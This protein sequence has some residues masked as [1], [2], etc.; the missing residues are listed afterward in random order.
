[1]LNF[2]PLIKNASSAGQHKRKMECR[3]NE[4]KTKRRRDKWEQPQVRD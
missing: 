1:M 4:K 3:E 2:Q